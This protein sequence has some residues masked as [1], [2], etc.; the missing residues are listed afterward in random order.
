RVRIAREDALRAR[1]R[2]HVEKGATFCDGLVEAIATRHE[3]GDVRCRVG[4]FVPGEPA[5]PLA[6]DREDRRS[7]GGVD[8]VRYPMT[9]A[10]ARFRTPLASC[11]LLAESRTR[12]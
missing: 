9:A 1:E 11:A 8:H 6:G 12:R 4:D 10:G 2:G 7:S 3:D 5:R